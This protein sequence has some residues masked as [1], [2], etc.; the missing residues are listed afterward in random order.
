MKLPKAK[1]LGECHHWSNISHSVTRSLATALDTLPT[2]PWGCREQPK[3]SMLSPQQ[4]H[5][6]LTG[7]QHLGDCRATA[8][9]LVHVSDRFAALVKLGGTSGPREASG[10]FKAVFI[11]VKVVG[12]CTRQLPNKN[13]RAVPALCLPTRL[14]CKPPQ[15]DSAILAT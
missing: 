15:L 9:H 14:N 10:F 4:H 5:A 12:T 1:A 11:S 13:P 8:S 7:A 2:A 6:H 3:A